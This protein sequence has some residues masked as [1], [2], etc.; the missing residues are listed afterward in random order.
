MRRRAFLAGSL[1]LL[2]V[3]TSVPALALK[4]PAMRHPEAAATA[5]GRAA[6]QGAALLELVLAAACVATA[7]VLLPVLWRPA[8]SR[9][10]GFVCTRTLEA[11]LIV[12]G[13]IALLALGD[14]PADGTGT[15]LVSV[16]DWAFLLGP[17]LI[18]AVNAL[19]LGTVLLQHRLVPRV[20]PII[21][22]LGVPLL[23]ASAV[24]TVLGLV[25]QVS[26]VAGLLALPIAAWEISLGGWLVVKG[27]RS[28]YADD[29]SGPRPLLD[30]SVAA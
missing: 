20:I 24:G 2:T 28:P 21:G 7:V 25:D 11:G 13:V 29:R 22:L 18:P 19:L 4:A 9:A 17:G 3:A 23:L 16:H 14:V 26:P 12:L 30:H 27:F 5:V 15:L 6:L 8:P 10:V 1:Y